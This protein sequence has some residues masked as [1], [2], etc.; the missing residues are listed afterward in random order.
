MKVV[1]ARECSNK[2]F[3]GS[4]LAVISRR[5]KQGMFYSIA[6]IFVLIKNYENLLWRHC[7]I[8]YSNLPVI[9]WSQL[10]TFFHYHCFVIVLENPWRRNT[11]TITFGSTLK[12]HWPNICAPRNIPISSYEIVLIATE[13]RMSHRTIH[14][15]CTLI[16][17]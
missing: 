16:L 3:E 2:S 14:H 12:E 7:Y 11:F 5:F 10:Y 1:S 13:K 6:L 15:A 8:L 4:S 9:K 17:I